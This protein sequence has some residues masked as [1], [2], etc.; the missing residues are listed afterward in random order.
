ML[1]LFYFC[2]SFCCF[3]DL[4]YIILLLLLVL[5]NDFSRLLPRQVLMVPLLLGTG[6]QSLFLRFLTLMSLIMGMLI[7]L[8]IDRCIIINVHMFSHL[9]DVL[10]LIYPYWINGL[11]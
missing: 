2:S 11:N 5:T 1:C 3:T 8:C 7:S 10:H 6:I 4:S 9:D